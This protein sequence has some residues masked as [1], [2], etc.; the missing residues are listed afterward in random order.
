MKSPM[1]L[2]RKRKSRIHIFRH[3]G[4]PIAEVQLDYLVD[5]VYVSP[6]KW[7]LV[8]ICSDCDH[9]NILIYKLP[10]DFSNS[11]TN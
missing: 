2:I 6:K 10:S 4:S 9:Q 11:Q 1:N 7:E 3:D 5:R 8:A